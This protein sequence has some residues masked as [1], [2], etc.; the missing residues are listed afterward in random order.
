MADT[1]EI[2][3]PTG[4]IGHDGLDDAGPVPAAGGGLESG[5][6]PG[7]FS[8][9]PEEAGQRLDLFLT[10]K[11]PE[12]SRA[13]IQKAIDEGCVRVND[14]LVPASRKLKAGEEVRIALP[15]LKP[16]G[17]LPEAIDLPILYEDASLLVIDKPAGLVVHPAP[18]HSAGTLV[19]ALLH[20]C[21][22]LSGI[23][24]VLRPG[25]VHRL[26]METSGLLVAAKSDAAHH[27]LAGQFKGHEVKKTYLALVYGDPK[28]DSGRIEAAVGRHPTDRKKMS[29][30]SRHGRAAV[31]LWRV[32]ER[33]GAATLL[34][35]DIETGRTHQIRV[36]LTEIGHPVIG[37]KVY[38]GTG[39]I[40][41][42]ADPFVRS[43]VKGMERQAL[44]AWRLS[45]RH[46][47][48]G[49]ALTFTAPLPKDMADLCEFLRNQA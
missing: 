15:E 28:D 2:K 17:V 7:A 9:L 22:D 42:I 8:V 3:S 41:T 29:T 6:A 45:F 19:N 4:Q 10:R 30:Q 40:K 39:R 31:S 21:Q 14:R 46:P 12:L 44:H 1:K 20:H 13:R 38:G 34:E 47:L 25:I 26:D 11:A 49:E 37:D 33:Y 24:G 16:C 5:R 18:G 43:R 23:G 32:R 35:V 27:G 48:T 36:H